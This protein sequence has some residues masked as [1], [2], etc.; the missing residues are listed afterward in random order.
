[1]GS[2]LQRTRLAN[3]LSPP[4]GALG[5]RERNKQE[6]RARV[7][8]AAR[9]L[10]A[11]QGVEGTTI[12]QIAEAADIGLGTVFSYAAS[13]ED[14]LVS[15]FRDEVGRAVERAIASVGEGPLI[16]QVLYVLDAIIVHH[17]ENVALARVFVKE[18]PFVD[19]GRHGMRGFLADL[20]DGLEGLIEE[21]KARGELRVGVPSRALAR[22]LFGLFFQHL[23]IWLGPRSPRPKLDRQALRTSLELQLAGLRRRIP[24]G[25]RVKGGRKWNR[26]PAKRHRRRP[27]PARAR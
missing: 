3:P 24:S 22:N 17:R 8:R 19:R 7:R 23:L 15:I 2:P 5:R 27:A 10:F 1:M 26:R 16:E 12:R 6:K 18:T 4:G 11:R 9:E 21:A 20:L 14:L 13:K 25:R